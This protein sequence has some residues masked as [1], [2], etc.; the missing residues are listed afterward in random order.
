MMPRSGR[1][2]ITICIV[3]FWAFLA[4]LPPAA[5]GVGGK[6]E[7]KEAAVTQSTT[8]AENNGK[9]EEELAAAR[10]AVKTDPSDAQLRVQLGQLLLRKG[11]LD[12]AK[13]SFDEALKLNP[14][15]SS[16][17]TGKG[18]VLAR[19]GQLAEAELA[20]KDALLLNPNPVLTHYELGLVYER[21][22]DLNKAVAEFKEGIR[23]HEQGR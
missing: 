13:S 12:G 6:G 23:K 20:L 7:T 8:T 5:W 3:V 2:S 19:K 11:D 17:K 15:S 9:I 22:G 4:F 14:R 10:T 18:I 1:Q 16:A 21:L